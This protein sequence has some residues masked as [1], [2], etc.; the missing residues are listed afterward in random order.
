MPGIEQ[1]SHRWQVIQNQKRK[2]GS[3]VSAVSDKKDSDIF[4]SGA[5]VNCG[6]EVD[7]EIDALGGIHNKVNN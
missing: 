3:S 4:C 5:V 7:G 2:K 1:Y 6:A